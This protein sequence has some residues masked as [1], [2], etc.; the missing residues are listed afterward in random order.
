MS[1]YVLFAAR[2]AGSTIV[3]AM[4]ELGSLAYEVRYHEFEELGPGS[5]VLAQHNLLGQ[6]PTLL[7]PDGTCM[8]ETAAITFHLDEVAP[9]LGLVPPPGDAQ[10]NAFLRWLAYLVAAIYPTFTYG[11]DPSRWVTGEVAEGYVFRN[12]KKGSKMKVTIMR[13]TDFL[14]RPEHDVEVTVK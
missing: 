12:K 3:E 1:G 14:P 5:A 8:T 2:G 9:S 13:L 7:L 10:R 11:D 4:L 6:V